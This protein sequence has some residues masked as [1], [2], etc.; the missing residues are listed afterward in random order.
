MSGRW[1][2]VSEKMEDEEMKKSLVC[3]MALL[4][5]LMLVSAVR[6]QQGGSDLQQK[7]AAIK[8]SAADNQAALRHYQW[9]ETTQLAVKGEVK[10]T[11]QN[12]CLY[13]N[14]GKVQK[15]P[16]DT[17]QPQQQDSGGRHGRIAEK[18]IEKKKEEFADYLQQVK[19][20]VQGYVPPSPE[21][22]Q[23]AFQSGNASINPS[24]GDGMIS[25]V[26]KNYNLPGD[27]MTL[28]ISAADKK[29]T[30]LSVN[31]YLSDPKDVVTLN[32]SFAT[33]PD[34]TTFAGQ[35]ILDATAKKA[36]VTITNGNYQK[37]GM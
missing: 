19:A 27:S 23:N 24:A 2:Q 33:L 28:S 36:V 25:L 14:D 16:I 6:A 13:D 20:L 12:S 32:V 9:I 17:G 11:K 29:M 7:V 21:K 4:V 34:G 30:G 18:I 8:Q 3:S 35:T 15:T 5:A 37:L 31:T 22:I 1:P 26:F 10:S